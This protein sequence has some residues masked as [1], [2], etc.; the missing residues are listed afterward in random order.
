MFMT[1]TLNAAIAKLA[2]LPP[3]EQDRV[4]RW[5]LQELTDDEQWTRKLDISQD[6][7]ASSPLKRVPTE[8]AAGSPT[9][10]QIG[11]EVARDTALLGSVR[12]RIADRHVVEEGHQPM[13][14]RGYAVLGPEN[15]RIDRE[16]PGCRAGGILETAMTPKTITLDDDVFEQVKQR[17]EAEG[18]TVQETANEAVRL[19]LSEDRWQKLVKRGRTYSRDMAEAPTDDDAVQIAVDAVHEHRSAR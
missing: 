4:G 15:V 7:S 11:C 18:K 10:I 13:V 1:R 5:L 16:E 6:L 8:P 2:A 12:R 3:D 9:S 14:I 19:G 17:A